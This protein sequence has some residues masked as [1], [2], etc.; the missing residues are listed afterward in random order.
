M[1]NEKPDIS[2]ED[3][4]NLFLAVTYPN[5]IPGDVDKEQLMKILRQK[6]AKDRPQWAQADEEKNRLAH[7]DPH[8]DRQ[9]YA[10]VKEKITQKA[11]QEDI[12][13]DPEERY[14]YERHK[15]ALQNRE[16]KK[17]EER[18]HKIRE[19]LRQRLSARKKDD[20]DQTLEKAMLIRKALEQRLR[21]ALETRGQPELEQPEKEKPGKLNVNNVNN[22]SPGLQPAT[23]GMDGLA[24][25]KYQPGPAVSVDDL[26]PAPPTWESIPP[27]EK[28]REFFS[29]IK[30][31]DPDEKVRSFRE[32]NRARR[33]NLK[34][35]D[36]LL[37]PR[38]PSKHEPDE[39]MA[40][41][42]AMD[43]D[44][45]REEDKQKKKAEA[46][47]SGMVFTSH[48]KSSGLALE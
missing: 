4:L 33:S 1:A 17:T 12:P 15:E 48:S 37:S 44:M 2:I 35:R 47:C 18:E 7:C 6:I 38:R 16:Q 43:M 31:L 9:S 46:F 13:S 27:K 39:R 32:F 24:P 41:G 21:R 34:N 45:D 3:A 42:M 14:L 23:I 11:Q 22:V 36:E 28:A 20:D 19:D 10:Q 25:L 30:D 26:A 8:P 5:G 29:A 40:M